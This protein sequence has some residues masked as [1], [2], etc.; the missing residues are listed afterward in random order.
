MPDSA[1]LTKALF[2]LKET[3]SPLPPS[4]A[5]GVLKYFLPV[6]F[7]GLIFPIGQSPLWRSHIFNPF[8]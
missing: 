2:C 4:T 8:H 5:L 7:L 6:F 3:L 1:A